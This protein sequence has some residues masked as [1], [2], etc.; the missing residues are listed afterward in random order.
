MLD[1][2]CCVGFLLVVE[3]RGIFSF[4][5][6]VA[7]HGAEHRLQGLWASVAAA[8]GL[9]STGSVAT[10]HRLSCFLA[11]GIFPD[12]GLNLCLLHW[13]ADPLLLSHQGGSPYLY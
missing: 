7:S 9:W 13:K 8:G 5:I 6:A 11:C 10:A 12:R 1:L 2:C 4:V 3:S